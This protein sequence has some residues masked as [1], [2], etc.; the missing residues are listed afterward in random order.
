[1]LVSRQKVGIGIM[2]VLVD[3][4]V[5]QVFE[6]MVGIESSSHVAMEL[7]CLDALVLN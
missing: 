4:G 1:M 3:L 5:V 7:Y 6:L 2:V